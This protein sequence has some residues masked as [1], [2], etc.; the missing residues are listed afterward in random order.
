VYSL[1]VAKNGPRLQESKFHDSAPEKGL[2]D[3]KMHPYELTGNT[4]SIHYLAEEL[5][6]RLSRKVIDHT[7]WMENMTSTCDGRQMLE[8]GI[9]FPTDHRSLPL[10]KEQ[11]GLKLESSKAPVDVLV[12]PSRRETEH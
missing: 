4:V 2:P 12:I 7:G 10:C 5:S 11:M 9:H 1:I 6:Q 8:T 3:L